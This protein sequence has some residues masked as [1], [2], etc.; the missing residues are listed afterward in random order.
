MYSKFFKRFFD[1]IISLL[2]ILFLWPVML[3][4][5]IIVICD[6][7][8]PMI[9]KTQ[10]VG[11]DC[12]PFDFYKFRTMRIDAPKDVAP[13]LLKSE[14]YITKVG[15]TLRKTSI[16]ELPQLF[17]ILKG[18]MSI[19]GPRPSGISEKDLIAAREVV[20]ANAVRPGLTGWAQVNGR[21]VL[22]AD[23]VSK[24]NFDGEYVKNIT[25][26]QDWKIFWMT[27]KLV[28]GMNDIVEGTNVMDNSSGTGD[29]VE[30]AATVVEEDD[31]C[32]DNEAKSVDGVED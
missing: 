29:I 30:V 15:N 31:N 26:K 16:D 18:D 7:E 13:R 27:V 8:G 25:F 24:A 23:V 21:D 4:V 12:K 28:L 19:I 20:G 9:F 1:I 14:D 32:S 6:S 5:G 11:K 3:I 2:G 10:R 17:C 22:A